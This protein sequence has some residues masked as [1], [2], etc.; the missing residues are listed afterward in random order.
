MTS[1][2]K[3][4]DVNSKLI[5][6][7]SLAMSESIKKFLEQRMCLTALPVSNLALK[8][9]VLYTVS[10]KALH[11]PYL[12]NNLDMKAAVKLERLFLQLLIMISCDTAKVNRSC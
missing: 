8:S 10:S 11:F 3:H 5:V 4:S 2:G 6:H 12:N 7:T 1:R 9:A